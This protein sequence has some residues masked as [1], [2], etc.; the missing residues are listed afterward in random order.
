MSAA[1]VRRFTASV[2]ASDAARREREH[3]RAEAHAREAARRALVCDKCGNPLQT[4]AKHCGLCIAEM[5][6]NA[7]VAA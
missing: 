5:A 7:S 4:P 6:E 2:A 1:A 3:E